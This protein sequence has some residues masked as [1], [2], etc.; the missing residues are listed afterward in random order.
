MNIGSGTSGTKIKSNIC[1]TEG[2][3]VELNSQ[4]WIKTS[5]T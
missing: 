3:N 2:E 5:Q 1:I 4:K